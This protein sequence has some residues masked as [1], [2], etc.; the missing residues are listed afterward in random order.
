MANSDPKSR[1]KA[2]EYV[3]SFMI[4][5]SIVYAALN[6]VLA[7]IVGLKG[8]VPT[9]DLEASFVVGSVGIVLLIGVAVYE[10]RLRGESE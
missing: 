6:L 1:L 9:G 3:G 2:L 4:V 7:S 10:R 8:G 5:G